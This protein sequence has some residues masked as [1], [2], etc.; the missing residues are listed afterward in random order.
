[1]ELRQNLARIPESH[2]DTIDTIVNNSVGGLCSRWPEA[3]AQR[4][5]PALQ[6]LPQEEPEY[7]QCM[8]VWSAALTPENAVH[9]PDTLVGMS[10]RAP[11][12][13]NAQMQV[14]SEAHTPSMPQSESEPQWASV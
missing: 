12:Q 8:R 10:H 6:C 13:E 11:P 2:E 1:M 5:P 4:S 9:V 14:P 7:R 3:G